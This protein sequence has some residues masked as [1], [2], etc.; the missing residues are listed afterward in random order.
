MVI[1]HRFAYGLAHGVQALA[2]APQVRHSCDEPLCQQMKHLVVGTQLDNSRDYLIR[3][4]IPGSPLRDVRG[5][6]DRA[7]SLRAAARARA[8][9]ADAQALGS[10]ELDRLL[11]P[12]F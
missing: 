6:L 12:L 2:N 10:P 4:D 8:D 11:D 7:R 3:R 1:A 9:V 5:S